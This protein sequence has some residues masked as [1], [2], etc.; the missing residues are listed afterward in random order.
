MVGCQHHL[1]VNVIAAAG[2]TSA[3]FPHRTQSAPLVSGEVL[4]AGPLSR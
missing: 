3:H 4:R 2:Q 1:P